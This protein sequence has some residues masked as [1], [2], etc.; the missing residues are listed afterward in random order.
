MLLDSDIE[1]AVAA[2]WA[3][4]VSGTQAAR[5]DKAFLGLV[6]QELVERGWDTHVARSP[7]DPR[8]VIGGHFRPAKSWDVVCRADDGSPRILVEFKSQVD[9]YGNNENNRYEEALG[10]G[11]DARARFGNQLV[12]GFFLVLCEEPATTRPTRNRATGLDPAFART[13]HIQRREILQSGSLLSC[14]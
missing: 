13:N 4:R 5:H 12:L 9:S 10:S 11:L 8:A 7:N 6:A 3:G 14:E 1:T 2:F